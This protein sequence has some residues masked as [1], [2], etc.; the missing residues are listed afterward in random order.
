L[1]WPDGPFVVPEGVPDAFWIR[2]RVLDGDGEPVPDALVETWQADPDGRFDQP[3]YP[4]GIAAIGPIGFADSP[5]PTDPDGR[6]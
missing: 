2:G 5:V 3:N 4:R 1:P 6:Y